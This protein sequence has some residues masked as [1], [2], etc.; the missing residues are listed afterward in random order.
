MAFEIA[1]NSFSSS[2]SASFD[3]TKLNNGVSGGNHEN[4]GASFN[5]QDTFS[6]SPLLGSGKVPEHPGR[7]D[8][9]T[10]DQGGRLPH[11]KSVS[12]T[13]TKQAREAHVVV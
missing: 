12:A 5:T 7:G 13:S 10:G 1:R 8:D 11:K 4:H 3:S 9:A 2:P 6:A